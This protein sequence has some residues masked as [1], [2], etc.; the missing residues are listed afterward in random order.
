MNLFDRIACKANYVV[1]VNK[2]M[3][4]KCSRE[5]RIDNAGFQYFSN[6]Y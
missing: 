6:I 4:Q 1:Y 2:I 5:G 3:P